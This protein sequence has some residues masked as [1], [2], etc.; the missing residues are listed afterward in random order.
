M[1]IGLI[2][3]IENPEN[4]SYNHPENLK[5]PNSNYSTLAGIIIRNMKQINS[6]FAG[7]RF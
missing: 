6:L 3:R 7:I 1:I 4:Q 2:F 5:N